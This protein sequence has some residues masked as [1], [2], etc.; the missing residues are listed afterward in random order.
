[1]LL[2]VAALGAGV[3]LLL[4]APDLFVVGASRIA[5]ALRVSPVAI[6]AVV[7]GFGTSAPELLVSALAALEGASDLAVGNILGSNIAN[8]SLVAG[9][10]AL[11]AGGLAVSSATLRREAPIGFLAVLLLAVLLQGGLGAVEGAVLLAAMAG[12]I[13]WI[14]R[15]GAAPDDPLAPEAAAL[16]DA[17]HEHPVPRE[18]LRTAVGLVGVLAAAQ[19]IVTGA[20]GLAVDAGLS[21]AFV[22]VVIVGVGTSLPEIATSIQAARR[23]EHELIVGNLFG[24]NMFNSLG[25]GGVVALL[26]PGELDPSLTGLTAVTAVVVGAAAWLFLGTRRCLTR[27]EALLL[28]AAYAAIVPF[29]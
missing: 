4:K 22:G 12:A 16:C 24:S 23:G 9:L 27:A 26:G 13:L 15:G 2:D 20:R 29:L 21:E 10:A 7:I 1:V 11:V 8:V 19:L 28:L 3:A 6:G 17:E 5:L 18:A 25:I 14:L